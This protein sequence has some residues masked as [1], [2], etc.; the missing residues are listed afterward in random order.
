MVWYDV[1]FEKKDLQELDL[2]FTGLPFKVSKLEG[3]SGRDVIYRAP[4]GV[5]TPVL[6]YDDG[7]IVI[8]HGVIR[9]LPTNIQEEIRKRVSLVDRL[10]NEK[11]QW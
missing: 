8:F 2:R 4:D 1:D 7:R 3:L 5:E 6:H 9:S 10:K 11:F